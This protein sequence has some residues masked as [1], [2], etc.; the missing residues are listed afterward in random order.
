M[1][2][3]HI[4][5]ASAALG[6]LWGQEAQ[7][8]TNHLGYPPAASKLA[9]LE[10]KGLKEAPAF[11]VVDGAGKAVLK[12]R[13]KASGP[14]D[15]WHKGPFY[16]AEFTD[17]RVPGTYRLRVL[18]PGEALR[19]Q[20]IVVQERL[21]AEVGVSD[22]LY[23]FKG[24]RCSGIYDRT[25]RA[26]PFTG[27][28]P[29]TVDAHGGWYD[30]SG[31]YSKYLSHLCYSNYMTP[32]QAPFVV[33]SML[34]NAERLAKAK[35]EALPAQATKAL[36]EA[37]HGA[38]WLVRMQDPEGYF[39]LSIFDVWSH[40]PTKRSVCA[41]RTQDGIKGP[42]YQAA[43]REGA[44]LT[45]AALARASKVR[46]RGEFS[47]ER[48]LAAAEKGFAHLQANNLKYVDNG[49]ENLIDDYCALL[50]ASEL[51]AATGKAAYLDAARQ[52]AVALLA[53]QKRD[54]AWAGHWG[55][56]EG[57]RPYFHAAEAGLP[58]VALLRYR[59]LEPEAPRQAQVLQAVKAY[60][61]FELRVRDEVANPFGLARQLV[62]DL[63]KSPRTS[64]F[65]PHAN[66]SGY[67]WQGENARLASL[68]TAALW[69][70]PLVGAEAEALRAYAQRQ[71]DW[72]LG[73][74]PYDMCM[75]QGR[76]RNNPEYE[77][78][79]RNAPGGVCNGITAGFTNERDIAFL[80]EPQGKDPAQLW[81]WSEQW[82]PHGAWLA[83]ALSS[84]E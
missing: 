43:F 36:E 51:Y 30:A 59:T 84:M 83:L 10:A 62:Q 72:I 7:I 2:L 80:P 11:E 14:V 69:A 19:S 57:G 15:Q 44:G 37:L 34:E 13:F 49:K 73:L 45:I 76:G 8:L 50:A 65:F 20:P 4:L 68:A 71:I 42:D 41:Y 74:N 33:W 3:R 27:G 78:A 64:F 16:T 9:V 61:A 29:G 6:S 25:D 5:L 18:L 22:L 48:Y 23:Y 21:L 53:R 39:Y 32:Q 26:V 40:D 28:R 24:Q 77:P 52:R 56:D 55:V 46:E 1:P 17:V 47:P 63:G 12:G 75:L 66:E 82:T 70:A 31:D 81:R 35:G 54:G 38:D 60:F 79:F 67:W 58:V